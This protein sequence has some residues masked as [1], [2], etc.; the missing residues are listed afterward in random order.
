MRIQSRQPSTEIPLFSR[1]RVRLLAIGLVS[2]FCSGFMAGYLTYRSGW[3]KQVWGP[4]LFNFAQQIEKQ[5]LVWQHP[6]PQLLLDIEHEAFQRLAF[7]RKQALQLS[8]LVKSDDDFVSAEVRYNDQKHK[9]KIRLKGDLIDHLAKDKWSFRVKLKGDKTLEGMRIFSLQDPATRN[10]AAEWVMQKLAQDMGLISL[11]Y[12]FVRLILNGKDW[13]IYAL[14]EHFDKRLIENNQRREGPI[15]R[16]DENAFWARSRQDKNFDVESYLTAPV[17][18]FAPK[19]LL[20]KPQQQVLFDM[21]KT[22]LLKFRES[23]LATS[24]I[25]DVQQLATYTALSDLTGAWHGNRWHNRRWY[26]NPISYKLEPIV[27]DN[28]AGHLI[29]HLLYQT[30]NKDYLLAPFRTQIFADPIFTQ[31]YFAALETMTSELLDRFFAQHEDQLQTVLAYLYS[32]NLSY[33]F[34]RDILYNNAAFIQHLLH[35]VPHLQ[36]WIE[37]NG[38]ISVQSLVELPLQVEYPQGKWQTIAP[39]TAGQ[40]SKIASLQPAADQITT[41]TVA[42]SYRVA[43]TTNLLSVPLQKAP[44]QAL[45]MHTKAGGLLHQPDSVWQ[46]QPWL[47]VDQERRIVTIPGRTALIN[48]TTVIPAG[49]KIVI[50][51]GASLTLDEGVSLISWS[52]ILAQGTAHN[53]IHI[54]GLAGAGGIAI[55]EANNRSDLFYTVFESLGEPQYKSWRLT[56]AVS[57]YKSNVTAA[58]VLF[59]HNQSEDALNVINAK[60]ALRDSKFINTLSDAFDGDFVVAQIQNTT[61]SGC[62]N[63]CIDVSGSNA[64]LNNIHM[65][66]IG[67][68]AISAGEGSTIRAN[69]ITIQSAE[70]GLA[71]KDSSSISANDLVLD[72]VRL[73]LTAFRKKPEFGPARIAIF[74]LALSEVEIP[75]L[76]E[77]KSFLILDGIATPG[78]EKNVSERQYGNEF[79]K[80]SQH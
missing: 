6:A 19:R 45:A 42:L 50:E 5:I 17:T 51:A 22:N 67:D 57:F 20:N 49:W 54:K 44:T 72:K 37:S 28:D 30:P 24:D 32:E 79:G 9:V 76:V 58:N 46:S 47:Q 4:Y 1:F 7:K 23:E 38:G 34:E 14:E 78:T 63:D 13:G 69:N 8:Q 66:T 3:T 41:N 2:L 33:T 52:P 12:Q 43:G 77:K 62:G 64:L 11:R 75:S 10:G 59:S 15:L 73:G 60:L 55:L 53:A 74:R 36:A 71:S 16:F 26:F 56:G 21:G 18:T 25:F 27:F 40:V 65:A 61:F 39:K 48:Q 31:A 35:E 68:K 80:R 29:H 70:I